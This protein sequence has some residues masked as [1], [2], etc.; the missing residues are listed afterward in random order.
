MTH[1][2]TGSAERSA[3]M[4]SATGLVVAVAACTLAAVSGAA[5]VSWLLTIA[6]VGMVTAVVPP[7]G[8]RL[9]P[10]LAG[11]LAYLGGAGMDGYAVTM[12]VAVTVLVGALLLARD[13][14]AGAV[15]IVAMACAGA[16]LVL[17]AW[18]LA[19][20]GYGA[21]LVALLRTAAAL[22]AAGAAI[23]AA[24]LAM[25]AHRQ[26]ATRRARLIAVIVTGAALVAAGRARW[27]EVPTTALPHGRAEAAL[28]ADMVPTS[29]AALPH[30]YRL[31]AAGDVAW[32]HAWAG[33]LLWGNADP[34]LLRARCPSLG[35]GVDI[36]GPW[37]ELARRAAVACAAVRG[38]PD[39]QASA[40][41]GLEDAAFARLAGDLRMEA[42]DVDGAIAAYAE[43][44]RR[45][46]AY[47]CEDALEALRVRG[48]ADEYRGRL[49]DKGCLDAVERGIGSW[50]V[51]N[52]RLN[53]AAGAPPGRAGLLPMG[54]PFRLRT[55]LD[56]ASDAMA[57]VAQGKRLGGWTVELPPTPAGAW[58][59]ALILKVRG[60]GVVVL[61]ATGD[62]GRVQT[63]VC[64]RSRTSGEQGL[65]PRACGDQ[66]ASAR[67]ELAASAGRLQ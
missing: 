31:W 3:P 55:V 2:L 7:V 54:T 60:E 17:I 62:D 58:P 32:S 26:E 22:A 24:R 50:G 59:R 39:A 67:V 56:T 18:V 16:A 65:D 64:G 19:R 25:P 35:S 13:A 49:A 66:W 43:A 6:V 12:I 30:L 8:V 10:Y 11:A 40:L 33:L 41:L 53:F 45:G 14:V 23:A 44:S 36:D 20:A 42:G 38:W 1:G 48:R 29:A 34:E 37:R 46:D 57:L 27:G 15:A 52:A 28:L 4:V 5:P 61:R 47:A 9:S 63:W 51:W 21:E